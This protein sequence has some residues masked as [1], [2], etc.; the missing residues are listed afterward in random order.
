MKLAHV[1]EMTVAAHRGDCYNY[2]ENTMTAFKAAAEAG[3]DM[4]EFDVHMTKD[5][6]LVVMH[7]S[8]VN[9]TT[10]GDGRISQMT[11]DEILAL[12]A[13]DEFS[14]EKVPTFNE[15]MDWVSKKNMMINIE[16]KEYY[17]EENEERCARC[18]D[19]VIACVEKHNMRERSIINSFDAWVLEYVYKKHGK[20]YMLHGFYPYDAMK[21]VS[22]DPAEYLYCACICG[23]FTKSKFDYLI[24]RGIEPWIGASVTQVSLLDMCVKFGGKLVTTNNPGDTIDKLKKLG[25]RKG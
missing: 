14:P 15:F 24:E 1:G 25:R 9:R 11:L 12:N 20:A 16:I 17:S 13:G 23:K 4:I 2:Y 19:E 3:A 6:A 5:G 8:T 18:I 21:N 7:D 22:I 10:N